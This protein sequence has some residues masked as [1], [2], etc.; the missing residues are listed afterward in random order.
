[1]TVSHG[2]CGGRGETYTE[3]SKIQYWGNATP[4]PF[5]SEIPPTPRSFLM[6]HQTG[7]HGLVSFIWKQEVWKCMT[8]KHLGEGEKEGGKKAGRERYRK[9]GRNCHPLL[10]FIYIFFKLKAFW[11][12]AT[13]RQESFLIYFFL[14]H[15]IRSEMVLD[16]LTPTLSLL[17]INNFSSILKIFVR[18]N[19]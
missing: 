16:F 10:P 18:T 17:S 5:S 9:S 6:K 3:H 13:W 8:Y 4:L 14:L 15:I 11:S 19:N 2:W 1:M 12:W 7:Y